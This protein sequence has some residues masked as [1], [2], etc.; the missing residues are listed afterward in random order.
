M[1]RFDFLDISFTDVLD[2]LLVALLL[3]YLY[4]LL[5]GTVAINI[6]IGIVIFYL[7]WKLTDILNLDVLSNIL[8]KFVSVGFFALIVVF[9]QE[10]RKF[11]LLIG[12]SNFASKRNV[13]RYF[14][15]FNQ[16]QGIIKIDLTALLSAAEKMANEKT[17]AI[18]VLERGN[19][20]DFI[21]NTGDEAN[22]EVSAQILETIFFKN[23]PLHDGAIIIKDNQIIATRVVLPVSDSTAIPSKFGLRHRAGIGISEKTDALVLVISEQSGKISYIKDGDFCKF[24]NTE[25]LKRMIIEDLSI[26]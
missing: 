26:F 11:L 23:S 8:G 20:L 16:N 22:I 10:I 14:N 13:I 2:I 6:F 4:K 12:S 1:S 9:Q 25:Y 7:I 19:N 24:K 21:K 3:Y 15:F 5:K 17:G 18:I